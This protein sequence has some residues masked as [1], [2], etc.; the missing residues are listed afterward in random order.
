MTVKMKNISKK[1]F[2]QLSEE[3]KDLVFNNQDNISI[4]NGIRAMCDPHSSMKDYQGRMEE[5]VDCFFT[6]SPNKK[7]K[8]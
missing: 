4:L 6:I 8:L 1:Q 3:E 2:T 5:L 7:L